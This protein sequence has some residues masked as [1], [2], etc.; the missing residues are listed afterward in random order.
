MGRNFF[1]NLFV[2][3]IFWILD[4]G[5]AGRGG[6]SKISIEEICSDSIFLVK[7]RKTGG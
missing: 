5:A 1:G 2:G 4:F 3:E 6:G 7:D